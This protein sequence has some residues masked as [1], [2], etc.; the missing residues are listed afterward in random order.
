MVY[1]DAG[2]KQNIRHSV[3]VL[4]A[5]GRQ[6]RQVPV[7]RQFTEVSSSSS[8]SPRMSS[9]DSMDGGRGGRLLDLDGEGDM[10]SED[11]YFESSSQSSG[12]SLTGA[13]GIHRGLGKIFSLDP[14]SMNEAGGKLRHLLFPLGKNDPLGG[15]M[16]FQLNAE[17]LHRQELGGVVVYD[18]FARIIGNSHL[19]NYYEANPPKKGEINRLFDRPE[20]A[21]ADKLFYKEPR[22]RDFQNDFDKFLFK[23]LPKFAPQREF[24]LQGGSSHGGTFGGQPQHTYTINV[25]QQENILIFDSRFENANLRRA[26]K[27]NNVEY[28]LWL[29]NDVNTKGHTQ[30]FYFKVIHQHPKCKLY[31]RDLFLIGQKIQ[32]NILNLAKPQSLYQLGMKP[33]IYSKKHNKLY[34]KEWFRGGDDVKYFQNEIPRK[35]N[36]HGNGNNQFLYNNNGAGEGLEYYFTLSFIYEFAEDEDEVWFAQAIPYSYGDLQKDLI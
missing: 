21:R 15:K 18:S 14:N 22:E 36:F 32:F 3:D 12:S 7:R 30:W 2:S 26:I 23:H 10:Q 17:E 35:S 20:I 28:N 8:S 19:I 13:P 4:A 31:H 16:V 6:S 5:E 24:N 33:C 29:E 27:V 11:D 9:D 34:G 1:V 25:P